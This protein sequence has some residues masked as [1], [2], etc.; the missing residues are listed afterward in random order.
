MQH[1]FLLVS[2]YS[3]I[4]KFNCIDI[5]QG[6]QFLPSTPMLLERFEVVA[7]HQCLVGIP[8]DR[9]FS[10]LTPINVPLD[11]SQ[12]SEEVFRKVPL[13][14]NI[15]FGLQRPVFTITYK[16]SDHTNVQ[17]QLAGMVVLHHVHST[18]YNVPDRGTVTL[19]E[20]DQRVPGSIYCLLKCHIR[21][22]RSVETPT[23]RNL[24]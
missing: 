18:D 19:M 10:S 23:E 16:I 8:V 15:I 6:S 4:I 14:F 2:V 7:L 24:S 20:Q 21:A 13:R 5:A 12:D 17:I 3:V 9:G 1:L 22:T 11:I